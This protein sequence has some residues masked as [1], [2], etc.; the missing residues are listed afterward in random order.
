MVWPGCSDC[1]STLGFSARIRS[2]GTPVRTAI[3]DSVSPARTTVVLG[4]LAR[5]LRDAGRWRAVV[6][7]VG[8]VSRFEPPPDDAEWITAYTAAAEATIASGAS[9]RAELR[10]RDMTSAGA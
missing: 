7:L 6:V 4:V 1:S 10:R 8:V 5:A 3:A 9:Q 2:S